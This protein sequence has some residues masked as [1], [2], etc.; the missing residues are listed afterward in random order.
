MFKIEFMKRLTLLF[1]CF[2]ISMS[3]AIAQ[4][5]Q[6]SGTVV[7]ETGEPV[8]GASVVVKGNASVGAVTDLD[9]KF[10]L[11]VPVSA[12]TLVVKYLGKQVLEV[13]IAPNVSVTL[14]AS[15]T[16]LDEV[17]VVAYGTAK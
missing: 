6:V 11:S 8:I 10:T 2:L 17:L 7:D 4:N 15:D 13:A 5:K 14:Q 1:T 3:L 16:S 12:Q 9:G